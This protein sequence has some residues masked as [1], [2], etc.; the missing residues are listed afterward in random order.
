[1]K[2]NNKTLNILK[3]FA[4]INPSIIV[5]PGNTLK[6]ISSSKTILARA[7]ETPVHYIRH[8]SSP[9]HARTA[10]DMIWASINLEGLGP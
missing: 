1:M 5:K 2:I 6:T 4:T 10:S 7:G 3:N 8:G 9:I